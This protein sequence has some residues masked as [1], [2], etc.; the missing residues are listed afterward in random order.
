MKEFT[1]LYFPFK[2]RVKILLLTPKR[3]IFV[4][5]FVNWTVSVVFQSPVDA[6]LVKNMSAIQLFRFLS[7][8][9]LIQTNSAYIVDRRNRKV[10]WTPI[11]SPKYFLSPIA[12]FCVFF[13][14]KNIFSFRPPSVLLRSRSFFEISVLK[15]VSCL[16]FPEQSIWPFHYSPA[17]RNFAVKHLLPFHIYYGLRLSAGSLDHVLL[18][19]LNFKAL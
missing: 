13:W 18:T 9:N 1:F 15:C 16:W 8:L 17:L 14:R 10:F 5:F 12:K 4:D 19:F 2:L 11:S 3:E 7:H 6:F